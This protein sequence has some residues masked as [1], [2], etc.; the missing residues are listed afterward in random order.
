MAYIGTNANPASRRPFSPWSRPVIPRKHPRLRCPRRAPTTAARLADRAIAW[1]RRCADL[2]RSLTAGHG[3]RA[4]SDGLVGYSKSAEAAVIRVSNCADSGN[5]SL[6]RAISTAFS[7]DTI[8]MRSLTC[9]SIVFS[10]AIRIDQNGLTLVGP[11]ASALALDGNHA[12]RLF[13]QPG[14]G[15]L[16]LRSLSL[17]N[18]RYAAPL[19]R[20]GCISTAGNIELRDAW[21]YHCVAVVE[22]G[23]SAQRLAYG[24]GLYA[25]GSVSLLRS[26]VF[27][28]RA[29]SSLPEF[30]SEAGGIFAR[31]D[32]TLVQSSIY[33]NAASIETR[34]R[35]GY[36]G[37]VFARGRLTLYHSSIRR[38]QATHYGGALTTKG[39]KATYSSI[40]DNRAGSV[41]GVEVWGD[42][43]SSIT[44]RFQETAPMGGASAACAL[45]AA[46]MARP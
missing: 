1:L 12:G 3:R 31:G 19:A 9:G 14:P 11:G 5:G 46:D 40:S 29:T 34:P 44:P 27:A 33:D 13:F 7:G 36:A 35:E 10:R 38:N 41:G 24:G 39:F 18:G 6:R 15:T 8:D 32:V 16:S 37:G 4:A 20:G 22:V 21:V 30:G 43:T 26:R 45:T 2:P 28:N 17:K 25:L 42:F 23:A